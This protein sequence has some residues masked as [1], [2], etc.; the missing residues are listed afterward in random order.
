MKWYEE[1]GE[2]SDV[3]LTSRVVV[4]RNIKGYSFPSK[5]DDNERETVQHL[6]TAKAEELG[7]EVKIEEPSANIPDALKKRGSDAMFQSGDE[8]IGAMINKINHLTFYGNIRGSNVKDMFS[9]VEKMVIDF[10]R[11]F[12]MAYS[13][14]LGFLTAEPQNVGSGITVDIVVAIPGI[15][16]SGTFP[17]LQKKLTVAEWR[18][19]PYINQN[20]GIK[21]PETLFSLTNVATLGIGEDKLYERAITIINDI[22]RVERMCREAIYKKNRLV[23]EDQYYRAYGLLKFCRKIELPEALEVL[24]WIRFGLGLIDDKETGITLSVINEITE[25][26]CKEYDLH[27]RSFNRHNEQRAEYIKEILERGE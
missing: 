16:K 19:K 12:D 22:I 7:Y 26:L 18:L 10:E 4:R 25:K 20:N 14:R 11:A 1:N 17:S 24:G 13:E 5:M 3:I 9:R 23:V 15:V 21:R 8:A 2:N 27:P 6:V